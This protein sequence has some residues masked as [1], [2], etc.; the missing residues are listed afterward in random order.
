MIDLTPDA[1]RR[2]EEYMTRIR[3]TLG[4]SKTA[5]D[6]EQSVREH[7]E[8]ALAG[9][10]APISLDR[11]VPVLDQLG[12]PERWVGD[13]EIPAWRRAMTRLVYGPEDW[14][15]AYA[16]FAITLVM[17]ITFPVGGFLLL[18]P[19]F[20]L[21]RAF[22]ELI[23]DRGERIGA[24]RWLV[25]PSIIVAL[26]LVTGAALIAPIGAAAAIGLGDGELYDVQSLDRDVLPT[27]ERVR[28]ETGF[29]A[30]AAGTWWIVL[31]GI[32]ALVFR[33]YRALFLPVTAGLRR[34]HALVLLIVG[35]VFATLGS[36][37]L[38]VV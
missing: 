24:R 1:K 13:D 30:M 22:T 28:I 14:R 37:L 11:L 21:S 10:P 9:V 34:G 32:Y 29:L 31:S 36:V 3:A 8:V 38:F 5:D 15:L 33:S 7:V 25:Y 4:A 35:V 18:L 23:A 20:V 6:V 19:A 16:A 26:A 27:I 2:F 17:F 12:S